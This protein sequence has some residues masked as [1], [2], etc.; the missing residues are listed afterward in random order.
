[1]K[2]R[3]WVR[4]VTGTGKTAIRVNS[5]FNEIRTRIRQRIVDHIR[6]QEARRVESYK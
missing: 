2:M 4:P 6:E 5:D 1:M 3:F